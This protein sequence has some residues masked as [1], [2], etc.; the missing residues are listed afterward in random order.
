MYDNVHIVLVMCAYRRK[1]DQI[2]TVYTASFYKNFVG[3]TVIPYIA[4]VVQI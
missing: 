3:N 2:G 1:I 4:V